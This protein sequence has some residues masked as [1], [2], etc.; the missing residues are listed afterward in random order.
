MI[1]FRNKSRL[2]NVR[3][4]L[5]FPRAEI[6]LEFLQRLSYKGERRDPTGKKR[7]LKL[8]F[9]GQSALSFRGGHGHS[10]VQ[11]VAQAS[12]GRNTGEGD[13]CE[14]RIDYGTQGHDVWG[15]R[16]EALESPGTP[17]DHLS[18]SSGKWRS[19]S[20]CVVVLNLSGT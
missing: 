11:E 4:L 14:S 3:P 17:S 13:Q 6:G 7:Y 15:P 18:S 19:S 20:T 10:G 2:P 9:V 5:V 16:N 1:S 8:S 12:N